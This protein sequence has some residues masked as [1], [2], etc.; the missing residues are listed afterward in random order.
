MPSTLDDEA[1]P[2]TLWRVGTHTPLPSNFPPNP[3]LSCLVPRPTAW[4]TVEAEAEVCDAEAECPHPGPGPGPAELQYQYQVALIQGYNGAADN[5]PGIMFASTSLPDAVLRSLLKHKRCAISVATIHQKEAL[6]QAAAQT[7]TDLHGSAF[8][9][10]DLGLSAAPIPSVLQKLDAQQAEVDA[11]MMMSMNG[12]ASA[13][14][15]AT[16]TGSARPRPPGVDTSPVQLHCR[17]SGRVSLDPS[18]D[19]SNDT[20]DFDIDNKKESMLLVEFEHFVIRKKV[21]LTQ[22]DAV[23][24]VTSVF[25]DNVDVRRILAKIEARLIQPAVSLGHT[26]DGR[27][28]FGCLRNNDVYHMYR[29][30]LTTDEATNTW[31]VDTFRKAPALPAEMKP[32]PKDVEFNYVNEIKC[33]L[34]YN[35]T[36]QIVMP[37]PIGW[38]SSYSTDGVPHISPYSFFADVARGSE[39]MCVAF[40]ACRVDSESNDGDM[41]SYKDAHRNAEEVG[42]FAWSVVTQDRAWEMNYSAAAM[43][44]E[45]SEFQAAKLEFVDSTTQD[46]TLIKAPI[47]KHSPLVLECKYVKTVVIPKRL[48]KPRE[49]DWFCIV[50]RVVAIRIQND[51]LVKGQGGGTAGSSTVIDVD[52]ISPVARLGYLQEYGVISDCQW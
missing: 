22:E 33:K 26:S 51:V 2:T 32:Y 6:L 35:P 46:N 27:P 8:S 40:I 31:Q 15:S 19:Q 21:L 49:R 5:P 41:A 12:V 7:P 30:V 11:V 9:F 52:K 50:G 36:K 18:D 14:G 3:F 20:N 43:P 39:N 10:H 44:R 4:I 25:R 1:K 16:G 47:V 34:G 23:N 29:P 38:L 48:G 37:R 42:D 17:L 28:R 45:E 24:P 13:H